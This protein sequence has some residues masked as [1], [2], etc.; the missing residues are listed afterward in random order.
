[1]ARTYGIDLGAHTVK[2]AELEGSFG[3]FQLVGY[4]ERRVPEPEDRE[5]NLEERVAVLTEMLDEEGPRDGATY[6]VGFPTEQASVRVVSLPFGDRAK[7]EQALSFEVEGQVPFDLDDMIL[8]SRILQVEP[9]NSKVLAGLAER[10]RIGG[11]LADLKISGADPKLLVIDADLLGD[12]A[13]EG[14][15]AVID[16]GHTRTLVSLCQDGHVIAARA[17]NGG[18]RALT[19]A[20]AEAFGLDFATAE[21]RKHAAGVYADGEAPPAAAPAEV[22]DDGLDDIDLD[23]WTE[24]DTNTGIDTTDPTI[25]PEPLVSPKPRPT[26]VP[27]RTEPGVEPDANAV[28]R[29]AVLP[30]L[31]ELRT[32][33]IH[34]EDTHGVEIEEVVLAGGGAELG[35]LRAWLGSVLGVPVRKATVS[36]EADRLDA[37]SR[38]A[39]ADAVGRKAAGGKGRLLDLR[40]EGFAFKGDLQ[41]LG[42]AL[43]WG[44]AALALFMVGGVAL[45][46]YRTYQLNAEVAALESEIADVVVGTFPDVSR[47][48]VEG[49]TSTAMAIMQEKTAETT[50]QVDALGSVISD[51]PPVLGTLKEISQGMPSHS[52]AVLDVTELSISSGTISMKVETGG[53]EDAAKI[54]SSLKGNARFKQAQKGDEKKRREKVRFTITIPLEGDESEEG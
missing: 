1:M 9:G 50:A 15:Q 6:G 34:F 48:K 21:A 30:L 20:L 33:L 47:S 38:F 8:S 13:G 23:S 10:D 11:L 16:I 35:G 25:P 43:R 44:A 29:D 7:V 3:R 32:T 53:F 45:F 52:T 26:L 31:L 18:G 17:L 12:Q 36:P 24:E 2:V 27:S 51:E 42:T 49:S 37:P 40:Q 28:L 54:E 39:L 41:V 22:S 5:S 4:R 14:V 19:L 46:G